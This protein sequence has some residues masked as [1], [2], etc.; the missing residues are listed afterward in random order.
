PPPAF[1]HITTSDHRPCNDRAWP[2][3]PGNAICGA[4][5][6]RDQGQ[7]STGRGTSTNS[8]ARAPRRLGGS[9]AAAS[10]NV[11]ASTCPSSSVIQISNRAGRGDGGTVKSTPAE[12][13][14]G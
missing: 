12:S 13:R 9:T 14:N 6:T 5:E 11:R 8:P 1:R 3:T 7:G 2:G 10:R 4:G